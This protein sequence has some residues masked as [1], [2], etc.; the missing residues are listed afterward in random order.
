M[1]NKLQIE[2]LTLGELDTNCYLVWCPWSLEAI[3]VDPSDSGTDIIDAVLY[4]Q[5]HPTAIILTHGHFDHVLG[6]LEVQLA[7]DIPS[8]LHPDDNFLLKK[9]SQSAEYWLKHAV[10]PVPP[11][12][13]TLSDGQILQIGECSLRVL[14]TPGHTPGSVCLTDDLEPKNT[15]TTEH[16]FDSKEPI[17]ISGDLIFKDGIGRTDFGYSRPMQ[18]HSS[19]KKLKSQLSSGTRCYPGHG[20]SFYLGG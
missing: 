15:E 14:H 7:F 20:E 9:A 10:D 16:N 5:L 11:A 8:F 13:N 17:L 4:R 12:T 3:I 19:I 6:L 18:L 2:T 1:S